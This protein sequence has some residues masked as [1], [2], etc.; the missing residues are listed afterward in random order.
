M[1][2]VAIMGSSRKNLNTH[3]LLEMFLNKY[4][5]K[6]EEINIFNLKDLDYKYCLS[7]YGC[8]RTSKCI[9]RDDLTDIY[10]LLEEADIIVFATP[11]YYNSVSALSKAFIDRM[12][13]YWTRKF[14]LSLDPPKEKYGVALIDGG[15]FEQKD[16]FLG[17]ELVFDHFFKSLSCKKHTIIE[18]SNTDDCPIDENNLMLKEMFDGMELDL[19]K[20]SFY[21]LSGGKIQN[22]IE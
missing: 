5:L 21:R 14:R 20:S 8:E 22:G 7:C 6:E 17:S 2:V 1:K 10:P 15:A 11:I 12:Q 4:N 18:V 19:N 9:L 3:N 13:V 16:Q